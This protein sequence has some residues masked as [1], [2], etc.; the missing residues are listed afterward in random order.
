[1]EYTCEIMIDASLLEVTKLYIDKEN[2]VIWEKGLTEIID[3]K[4][5]L[6]ETNSEGDLVFN[7]DQKQMIMHVKVE[8]NELPEQIIQIFTVPG[9]WNRCDS[10]FYNKNGKTRWVMDVT[11]LFDEDP[12][13]PVE[14][15]IEKTTSGMRVF[16]QFVEGIKNL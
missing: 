12:K 6:F 5:H 16:K 1:M 10:K 2:M 14:R 13:L 11:F 4:G 7:F 3:Q 8:K 9:A 15:F